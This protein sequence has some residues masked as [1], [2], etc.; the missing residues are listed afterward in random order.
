MLSPESQKGGTTPN[1]R[2]LPTAR[3]V[4]HLAVPRSHHGRRRPG[5]RPLGAAAAGDPGPGQAPERAAWE[6]GTRVRLHRDEVVAFGKGLDEPAID[7]G[8]FVLSKEIFACQRAAAAED[9]QS[10]AGAVTRLAAV[11]PVRAMSLPDQGWW[12]DVDTPHDLRLARHQLRRSLG[13]PEDGPVAQFLNRPISTR[14][15]MLLAP[16][17]PSP[18]LLSFVALGF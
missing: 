4:D 13:C 7:C 3:P 16:L 11:R 1:G 8:A 2:R 6:E 12:Q 17:R 9:D 5:R 15:S 18:S 10:L 14:L